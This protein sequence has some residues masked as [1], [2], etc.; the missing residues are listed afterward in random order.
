M[1]MLRRVDVDMA[2][3][4]RR[5]TVEQSEAMSVHRP[6]RGGGRGSRRSRRRRAGKGYGGKGETERETEK[7]RR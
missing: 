3:R 7:G 4:T 2:V 5:E 6:M 1:S